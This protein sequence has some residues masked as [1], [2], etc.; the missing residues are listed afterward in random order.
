MGISSTHDAGLKQSVVLVYSHQGF[1]DEYYEAEVIHWGFAR[2]V[3]QYASI[4]S[5][6]PVLVLARTIDAGKRLLV[7]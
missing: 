4:G 7:Q 2:S 1:N 5:K 6:A 3:Q